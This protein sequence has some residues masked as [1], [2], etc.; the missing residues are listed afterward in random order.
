MTYCDETR[1][2]SFTESIDL[3]IGV[4][5]DAE[6]IV[7]HDVHDVNKTLGKLLKEIEHWSTP[8]TAGS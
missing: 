2:R 1:R 3:D 6:H 8:T 5:R 4:Y 7:R